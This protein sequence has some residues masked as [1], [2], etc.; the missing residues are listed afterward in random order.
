MYP[1]SHRHLLPPAIGKIS[2]IATLG[3]VTTAA[4]HTFARRRTTTAAIVPLRATPNRSIALPVTSASAA[5]FDH[6]TDGGAAVDR[7]GEQRCQQPSSI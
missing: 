6:A 4:A 1:T 5:W 3:A 2:L 7:K